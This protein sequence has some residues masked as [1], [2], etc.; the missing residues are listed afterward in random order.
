MPPITLFRYIAGRMIGALLGLTGALS[1]IV[2][3][4]DLVENL[5]FSGKAGG[6]LGF[7]L[8]LTLLRT[9]AIAQTL[10]PF[11]FLFAAIWMFT[12]LNRRSELAVMRSAGLS[13]WRLVGPAAFL[14]AMAGFFVIVAV[15]PLSARM[16][17]YAETM[18]NE[19]R[20]KSSSV[21]QVF[22]D[23]I[24]LRQ[25]D[26]SETMLINAASFDAAR[27]ALQK[28]T[29][30]RLS[31]DAAFEER[32]DAPEAQ[33]AGRTIELK[34]AR[35]KTAGSQV[36][37]RTPR[38]SVP[39]AL[40]LSALRE[41]VPMPETMSIWDLPR[42]IV[43]AEQVGLATTRYNIRFHDLCSTPLKLTAMVLIAALFSLGPMRSGGAFR[44]LVAAVG[45][46]F[47]LYVVSE[48]STAFGESGVA[49]EAL[50]AW[51]PAIVAAIVAVSLLM[52]LEE[53]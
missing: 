14:A 5:R 27:G 43:V 23:G 24:W 35:M 16:T 25:S 13:V 20:G 37:Q 8:Q 3:L 39:T 30:W 38:Y 19:L 48:I 34:D 50:A 17:A 1:A 4:A 36:T 42:F 40:T 47:A 18:K 2:M 6:D 26:A 33:L 51:T 49:P 21:V 31:P 45:S 46:G 22:G 32:I 29:I 44:L 52:R 7:A 11:I 10:L 12:Q 41:N 9:P 53:A 28:V 15:D